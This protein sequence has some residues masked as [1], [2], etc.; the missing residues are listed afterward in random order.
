MNVF[1]FLRIFVII[2]VQVLFGIVTSSAWRRRLNSGSCTAKKR[3]EKKKNERLKDIKH[4]TKTK[5]TCGKWK[6][7]LSSCL[8]LREKSLEDRKF[9]WNSPEFRSRSKINLLDSWG[10]EGVVVVVV[11]GVGGFFR[12]DEITTTWWCCSGSLA[13]VPTARP[14]AKAEI[15]PFCVFINVSACDSGGG[16]PTW[17]LS[18][19]EKE[20]IAP[21]AA[22]P[23]FFS[24]FFLLQTE[25]CLWRNYRRG[26]FFF[27][28]IRSAVSTPLRLF[29]CI[30]YYES[31]FA[32][33][34]GGRH[35]IKKK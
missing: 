5:K 22:S 26:F 20:I 21:E 23:A 35:Q 18:A 9:F 14:S 6:T 15:L 34:S 28:F 33:E 27:F 32:V 3:K 2:C 19:H 8:S 25:V 29:L 17:W 10:E 30:C 7:Q 4:R 24:L 31:T 11:G 12:N 1:L 13:H 16:R